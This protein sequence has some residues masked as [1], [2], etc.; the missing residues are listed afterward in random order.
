MKTFRLI[1]AVVV[2]LLPTPLWAVDG[3]TCATAACHSDLMKKPELHAPMKATG[4]CAVCHQTGTELPPKAKPDHPKLK[5]ITRSETNDL[6]YVCHDAFPEQLKKRKHAHGAIEKDSCLG[7]HDPHGSKHAKLLTMKLAP[8]LCLSCHEATAQES[9]MVGSHHGDVIIQ[10]ESCMRCHTSH[11][12]DHKQLLKSAPEKQCVEC[13]SKAIETKDHRTLKSVTDEIKGAAVKHKPV[14]N[15]KCTECHV[16]HGSAHQ[17]LLNDRYTP[18]YY[19]KQVN[20]ADF[21]FCYKCHKQENITKSNVRE[22]TAFRNGSDNLHQLHV[23]DP[24]K[25]RSCRI[26]HEAHVSQNHALI[27]DGYVVRGVRVPLRFTKTPGGGKC[28]TACHGT[29]EYSRL[30]RIVNA[31]GP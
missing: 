9:R 12:A 4:G 5:P 3:P 19:P 13:H 31:P 22:E 23:L 10:G 27:T 17:A 30:E 11:A 6:C 24:D 29:K 21:A 2:G 28:A 25:P 26:C 18:E 20:A 7:C 15:G 14:A 1:F 8:E 16:S